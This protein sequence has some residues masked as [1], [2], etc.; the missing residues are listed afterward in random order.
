AAPGRGGTLAG[1]LVREAPA[2]A[3]AIARALRP[4]ALRPP[5]A[6]PEAAGAAP[7]RG[8]APRA[9][10]ATALGLR[11]RRGAVLAGVRGLTARPGRSCT[12]PPEKT[13]AGARVPTAGE[14]AGDRHERHP[15]RSEHAAR[16]PPGAVPEA[17]QLPLDRA[18]AGLLRAAR[19]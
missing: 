1:R 2:L 10:A 12:F 8:R 17:A 9:A 7:P 13:A 11:G 14:P 4:A 16:R 18:R 5:P 19:A 3:G 6:P 15:P